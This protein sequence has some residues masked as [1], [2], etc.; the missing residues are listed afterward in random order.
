M[1]DQGIEVDVL[2]RHAQGGVAILAAASPGLS[3]TLPVG[4]PVARTPETVLFDKSFHKMNGV[5]V[6]REPIGA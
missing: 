3:D 1:G 6:F 4:C 5:A 2:D